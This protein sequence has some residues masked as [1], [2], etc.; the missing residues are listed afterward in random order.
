M[1]P[2]FAAQHF[3]K[4]DTLAMIGL[5]K[6]EQNVPAINKRPQQLVSETKELISARVTPAME[7][8]HQYSQTFLQS[9]MLKVTFDVYENVLKTMNHTLDLVLPPE[10]GEKVDQNGYA[11]DGD[12]SP[13]DGG[14]RAGFLF[15][16]TIYFFSTATRRL[17]GIA[18]SRVDSAKMATDQ[19]VSNACESIQ[20]IMP[21][22]GERNGEAK[23]KKSKKAQ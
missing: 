8:F 5:E 23:S 17:F 14:A 20:K 10:G 18:Q 21:H 13:D 1:V 22:G 7:T 19:A 4:V 6:L 12:N 3:A 2:P 11:G 15:R 9:K 16:K